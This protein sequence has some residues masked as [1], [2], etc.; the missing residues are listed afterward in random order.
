MEALLIKH[1]KKIQSDPSV[2]PEGIS[3]EIDKSM[4][5]LNER[6]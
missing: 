3:E 5:I 1:L 4:A 2:K 6:L